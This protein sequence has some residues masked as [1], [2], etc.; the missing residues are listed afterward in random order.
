[1]PPSETDRRILSHVVGLTVIAAVLVVAFLPNTGAIPADTSCPYGNCSTTG[2][3]PATL[4]YVLLGA[5]VLV[6][7]ALGAVLLLRRRRAPAPAASVEP[8]SGPTS[9]TLEG[10]EGAPA[11]AAGGVAP[12]YLETPED[13]GHPG[14][15]VPAGE[16]AAPAEG[17]ADIDSLMQELD[18]IS[19]EI[20]QRGKPQSKTPPPAEGEEE[21]GDSQ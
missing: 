4:W 17:G 7:A 11:A 16:G 18:K 2:N 3:G 20:L 21:G 8:W 15:D 1:M 10:P 13:V 14:P 6:A 9:G 5:L 19:G 12:A